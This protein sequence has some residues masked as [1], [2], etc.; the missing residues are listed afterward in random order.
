MQR[1]EFIDTGIL[2]GFFALIL[3]VYFGSLFAIFCKIILDFSMK[4][5]S[6]FDIPI[7]E[8]CESELKSYLGNL[9]KT[10]KLGVNFI[11][12]EVI[13]RSL[14]NSD[15]Q[16]VVSKML[17][18]CDGKGLNWAIWTQNQKK[19]PKFELKEIKNS[20]KWQVVKIETQTIEKNVE[21][22]S[23]KAEFGDQEQTQNQSQPITTN[24][25]KNSKLVTNK[26]FQTKIVPKVKFGLRLGW[27][28]LTGLG[29]LVGFSFGQKVILG[30][31]FVREIFDLANK[32][33]WK[34]VIIGGNNLVQEN[35]KIQFPKLRTAF[36]FADSDSDLMR[37]KGVEL[38]NWPQNLG[39]FEEQES[40]N[41]KIETE[42]K[43]GKN[44]QK[45]K[46]EIANINAKIILEITKKKFDILNCKTTKIENQTSNLLQISNNP[47]KFS[48]IE[49]QTSK[50]KQLPI[51]KLEIKT[52]ARKNL[53]VINSRKF[54]KLQQIHK[55]LKSQTL[56]SNF[57]DLVD[58][59]SW[60]ESLN[61]KQ[62]IDLVLICIGGA[63]GKQEFLCDLLCGNEKLSFRS[64]IC[65]GA[66]LDHLG[67]GKKQQESPKWMQKL[68]L[69]WLFRFVF[70]P[71]RRERIWDSVVGLW[72][73]MSKK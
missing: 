8:T 45:N 40:K 7:A 65:L 71:Y 38:Q 25:S 13:L 68:G 17:N 28:F 1:K 34:I 41:S 42:N 14:R 3:E 16:R 39:K 47:Q 5:T 70:Q 29:I 66:A 10:A 69:E 72:W 15:Y 37:D 61:Q 58:C 46:E 6:L 18:I 30:R 19:T 2:L 52:D 49:N 35:L 9:P 12:S 50:L 55:F 23:K 48:K 56:L 51:N 22:N 64:A 36:W 27:N 67:G 54:A 73:E 44:S 53:E 31:D 26:F 60:L 57:P 21:Q 62:E 4:F 11:Y 33:S 32:K 24:F 63:S 20:G 59:V 43:N